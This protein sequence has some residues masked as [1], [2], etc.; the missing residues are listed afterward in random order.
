VR[1]TKRAVFLPVYELMDV[2]H[3]QEAIAAC[4]EGAINHPRLRGRFST[5]C[6]AELHL[7]LGE[8]AL[9]EPIYQEIYET[10][11]I[12]WARLGQA[13]TLF[14]RERYAEAQGHAGAAA[15]PEQ[16]LPRRL[17]LA[18]QDPRALGKLPEGKWC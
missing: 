4:L 16:P 7:L 13:K 10:K 9:A 1:S 2:G 3:Q 5:A 6:R 17:R 12:P 15:G 14:A 8:P 18:G 11:G